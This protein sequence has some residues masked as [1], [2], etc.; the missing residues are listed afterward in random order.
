MKL[1]LLFASLFSFHVQ[2]RSVPPPN[3]CSRFMPCGTY[4][5]VFDRD[6]ADGITTTIEI[7][8]VGLDQAKFIYT[9]SKAGEAPSV[10]DL[11]ATFEDDGRFVMLK[12]DGS[13]YAAGIC[14]GQI[15]T[16]GMNPFKLPD[17]STRGNTGVLKFSGPTL[18]FLMGFGTP[19]DWT[20]DLAILQRK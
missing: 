11:T 9:L 7:T 13:I 19:K 5:G 16:Y 15:C 3:V 18:E 8:P 20:L 2:A 10:W 14:K 6:R 4:E 17:G 1:L 12:L